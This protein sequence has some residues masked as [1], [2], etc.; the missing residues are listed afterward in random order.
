M[1]ITLHKTTTPFRIK[2]ASILSIHEYESQYK[3]SRDY[4]NARIVYGNTYILIDETV[5]EVE[6]LIKKEMKK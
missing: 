1:F 3:N 2:A 4:I 5:N 6:R